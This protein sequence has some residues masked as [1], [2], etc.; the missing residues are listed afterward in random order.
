MKAIVKSM[1]VNSATINLNSYLP[2]DPEN[3]GLWIE[4]SA[5]PTDSDGADDYRILVCTPDWIKREYGT[6][7]AIHG[8]HMLIVFKY[9]ISEIKF[10]IHQC[11]EGCN[12]S[13]FGEIAPKIARFAAW[14]FE[15]YQ[16]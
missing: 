16:P 4:F 11:V 7:K 8:R 3:F 1:W 10:A 14:E 13:D 12:G 15:D 2:D 9:D 5:G 6:K